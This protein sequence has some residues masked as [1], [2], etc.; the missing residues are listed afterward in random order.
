MH[1][2]VLDHRIK[3]GVKATPL[4]AKAEL[5]SK[6]LDPAAD[7]DG[8]EERCEEDSFTAII[9]EGESSCGEE[10]EED[11]GESSGDS[12]SK[13]RETFIGEARERKSL[14]Q[15]C[16]LVASMHGQMHFAV[17]YSCT[18]EC[19]Y[20]LSPLL[21]SALESVGAEHCLLGCAAFLRLS[22]NTD[23]NAVQITLMAVRRKCR[24]LGI[25]RYLMQVHLLTI[26]LSSR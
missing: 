25:G 19:T 21:A 26:L 9:S 15:H 24:K 23:V 6:P 12:Y 16:E 20:T 18:S 5:T 22:S 14:D 8:E 11:G 4:V 13:E 1:T 17:F 3:S 2:D 10:E 7:G